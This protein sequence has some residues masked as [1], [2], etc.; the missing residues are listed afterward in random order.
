ME[1]IK[2]HLIQHESIWWTFYIHELWYKPKSIRNKII[3]HYNIYNVRIL[4]IVDSV[5]EIEMA[6]LIVEKKN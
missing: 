5:T 1:H 3:L 6:S 4:A 2:L